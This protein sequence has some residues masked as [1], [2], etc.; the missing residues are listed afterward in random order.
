MDPIDMVYYSIITVGMGLA[1]LL[2]L[3]VGTSIY[4][5]RLEQMAGD[6]DQYGYHEPGCDTFWTTSPDCDCGFDEARERA[7]EVLK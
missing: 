3:W 1:F 4:R 7:L 5:E 2:G 6:L